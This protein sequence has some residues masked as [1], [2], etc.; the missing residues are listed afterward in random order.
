[1]NPGARFSPE[2]GIFANVNPKNQSLC[3]L[4]KCPAATNG[5]KP[6]K[7]IQPKNR[8]N[9]KAVQFTRPVT[10]K[11][12]RKAKRNSGQPDYPGNSLSLPC[13]FTTYRPTRYF[14]RHARIHV[15][16]WFLF[17][18]HKR[19][20]EN[21]FS[22]T[23]ATVPNRR[24]GNTRLPGRFANGKERFA[25]RL[26]NNRLSLFDCPANNARSR[27]D[28][29][30]RRTPFQIVGPVVGLDFVFVVYLRQMFRVRYESQ[31]DQPINA[32]TAYLSILAKRN[33]CISIPR[34]V[35]FKNLAAFQPTNTSHC[36]NL[37][38][39]DI[40]G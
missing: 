6:A 1:M 16:A 37:V 25:G 14:D 40:F 7:S 22:P 24:C 35:G 8:P 19:I 18:I 34:R 32:E 31:S 9:A 12:Q 28:I 10:G 17:S 20:S 26:T 21:I 29:I 38:Q 2:P 5:A 27:I 23:I 11:S 30:F 3:P 36:A 33:A 13:L 15:R 4:E 39:P